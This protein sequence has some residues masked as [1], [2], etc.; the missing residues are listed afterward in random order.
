M[1]LIRRHSRILSLKLLI[2]AVLSAAASVGAAE[3]GT[4]ATNVTS[5]T[6]V[7]TTTNTIVVTN[8]VLATN[9]VVITVTNEILTTNFSFFAATPEPER[10]PTDLPPLN[11]VPP[12]DRF[13]WIQLKSGEWLKGR[14]KAM[15]ERKLD[16]ESD[17]LDDQSF[18]WADVR[19]LRSTAHLDLLFED[20]TAVYGPVS[21]TPDLVRMQTDSA[22][23]FPRA[24]LL[25]MTPG[26]SRLNLWSGKA[27]A[28]LTI[29]SGNT[30]QVEY[31]AQFNLQRRSPGTRLSL[32]YIGNMSQLD[33]VESANNHRVNSEFD[34]WLSRRLFLV[35]PNVEY[36]RD[37]FQNLAHRVTAAVG[38]G[39]DII[40][41]S[42]VEWNINAGP[43]YQHIWFESTQPGEPLTRGNAALTFGSRLDWDITRRVELILEYRG[44]Y[45]SKEAGDTTHHAVGTLS[46]EI[47]KRLDVDLS[48][49][50]D[51]ISNPNIGE[52]GVQP[53]K[54]DFRLIVGLGLD[55]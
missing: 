23:A 14:F 43:G 47:T 30:E 5:I 49:V 22:E 9:Y 4:P 36:Y 26:G 53:K 34:V 44:Q 37:P 8:Q 6:N 1:E 48:L 25:S 20:G 42:K 29:R 45:A 24:Q 27:S 21:V 31:N 15:Q 40:Y 39:Y 54:D 10:K 18:D 12:K 33:G 28:G 35:I 50:W 52:D 51:R 11:W 41:T 19:Q 55:F 16:F 17:E 2:A 13:D 38:V 46:L 32:D 3:S 7:I